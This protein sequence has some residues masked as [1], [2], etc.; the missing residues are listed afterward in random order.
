MLTGMAPNLSCVRWTPSVTNHGTRFSASSRLSAADGL[1]ASDLAQQ[2]GLS[3]AALF[4][5]HNVARRT[6]DCGTRKPFHDS[7]NF[8]AMN[9]LID[10]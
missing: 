2:P 6:R 8:D 5:H 1:S 10:F 4:F 9:S 7:A 3:N